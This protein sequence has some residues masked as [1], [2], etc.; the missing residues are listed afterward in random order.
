LDGDAAASVAGRDS[1][2][3]ARW[4]KEAMDEGRPIAVKVGASWLF[5]K[6]RLLDFIERRFKL[7]A[8]R[9]AETRLRKLLEIR[10]GS[11]QSMANTRTRALASPNPCD[12]VDSSA[13]VSR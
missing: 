12:L 5:V 9:E 7:P 8:R 3:V 13:A 4:A 1:S 11:Q 6:S 10:A 2:T